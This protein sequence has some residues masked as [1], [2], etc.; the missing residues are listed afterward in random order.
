[1]LFKRSFTNGCR[2][3]G[4]CASASHRGIRAAFTNYKQKARSVVIW[5]GIAAD[6]RLS[7]IYERSSM[8]IVD[9][10][11][12]RPRIAKQPNY[13][14]GHTVYGV[15][16]ELWFMDKQSVRRLLHA[17]FASMI[18]MLLEMWVS[19]I[20]VASQRKGYVEFVGQ[21]RKGNCS[22]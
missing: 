16:N 2:R 14:I 12:V 9:H 15:T 1:M 10:A 21:S 4:G 18:Y 11:R 20:F 8:A 3:R 7:M 17:L 5:Q 19:I 6:H 22:I 13:V